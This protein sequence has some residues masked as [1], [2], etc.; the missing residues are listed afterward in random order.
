MRSLS[1]RT[2]RPPHA[3]EDERDLFRRHFH[4]A[5]P[6]RSRRVRPHEPPSAKPAPAK[7]AEIAKPQAPK[8]RT[9]T[10]APQPNPGLDRATERRVARG[11]MTIDRRIDLHGLTLEDAHAALDRFVRQAVRDGARM[12]LVIT[13]K[14]MRSEG[15]IKRETP[16]WLRRGEHAAQVLR[17]LPARAKHGGEGALYVLLRR[18]RD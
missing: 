5:K 4:D 15:A 18:K 12:L 13:G 6:L 17:I 14:G 9:P 7:S 1:G 11:E 3:T 8:I 10:R 2:G 16:H